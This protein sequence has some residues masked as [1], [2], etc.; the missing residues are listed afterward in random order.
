MRTNSSSS[1]SGGVVIQHVV[2]GPL[3]ITAQS[4]RMGVTQQ[5]HLTDRGTRAV[6]GSRVHRSALEAELVD[7]LGAE[8]I[9]VASEVLAPVLARF[10]AADAIRNRRVRP[11]T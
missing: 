6:V 2:A 3:S 5:L 1:A 7:D 11:P 10:D 8:R 9:A 4:E